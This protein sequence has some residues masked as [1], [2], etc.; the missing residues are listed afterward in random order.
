MVS[1]IFIAQAAND[2]ESRNF[3]AHETDW[4]QDIWKEMDDGQITVH[5]ESMQKGLSSELWM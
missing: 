4:E 2:W 3:N 5:L 1:L